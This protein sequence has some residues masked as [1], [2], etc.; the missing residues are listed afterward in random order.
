MC[1]LQ[2][3]SQAEQNKLTTLSMVKPL[4]KEIKINAILDQY[5]DN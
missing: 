3:A 1:A 2:F 4:K 5:L